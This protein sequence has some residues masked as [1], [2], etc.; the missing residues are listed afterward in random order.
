VIRA[1]TGPTD[2]HLTFEDRLWVLDR[3][4][5]HS[6]AAE[7]WRSGCASGVDTIAAFCAAAVDIEL[8]LYVPAAPH[9]FTMVGQLKRSPLVT[10]HKLR[11]NTPSNAL[12]YR[13][14][15]EAMLYGAAT[16]LGHQRADCLHAILLDK[17][18]YRS[19]EWMTVN[20]AKKLGIPVTIDVVPQ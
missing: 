15:N 5:N 11:H 13:A 14:R 17:E 6:P 10:L 8:E 2:S 20:I 1:F 9:N 19:G 18:F 4:A 16:R 7:V 12:A 3:I